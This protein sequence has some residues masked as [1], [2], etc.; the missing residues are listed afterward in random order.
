MAYETEN[1]ADC[2][3]CGYRN[4]ITVAKGIT[5]FPV[6]AL[7][8]P[9]INCER[10]LEELKDG[11]PVGPQPEAKQ[12][13][14]LWDDSHPYRQAL[15][16]EEA[17]QVAANPTSEQ[18]IQFEALENIA[19]ADARDHTGPMFDSQVEAGVRMAVRSTVYALEGLGLLAPK[20]VTR[21]PD[22]IQG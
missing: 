8:F 9:C 12:V 7:T 6:G 14:P 20:A 1:W 18:T 16:Q 15:A 11:E 4:V 22:A 17:R 10:P 21:P 5:G 19:M 13:P 3:H 2:P